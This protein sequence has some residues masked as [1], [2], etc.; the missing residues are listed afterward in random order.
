[1][2]ETFVREVEENLRRDQMRDFGKKYGVWIALLVI[3]FL[4]ASGGYIY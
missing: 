1:M 3:L 2:N 4:V